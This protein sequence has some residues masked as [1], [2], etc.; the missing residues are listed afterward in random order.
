[1]SGQAVTLFLEDEWGGCGFPPPT[2][3][4]ATEE[5]ME[6]NLYVILLLRAKMRSFR[7]PSG[8]DA[9]WTATNTNSQKKLCTLCAMGDEE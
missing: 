3:R 5:W 7:S 9:G 6:N 2:P 1:M 4:D 8:S